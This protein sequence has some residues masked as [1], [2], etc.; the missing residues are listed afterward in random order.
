MSAPHT[1]PPLQVAFVCVQNAGR[2]QMA[3]AY[4]ERERSSRDLEDQ[5]EIRTG[6]TSPAESVHDEV[7][8]VLYGD[9]IDISDRTPREISD[10][11]LESSD[12][13]VT[14]GCSTLS[15]PDAV[16][17]RDW[18]LPDPHGQNRERVREIRDEI[19]E[20]VSSLFDEF[21]AGLEN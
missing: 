13:V 16:D 8:E 7:V 3:T 19:E 21:E 9:K 15:L 6:G 14:M 12:Y 2:S 20:R 18:D 5:I 4:A 10:A 17:S 1:T 11:V